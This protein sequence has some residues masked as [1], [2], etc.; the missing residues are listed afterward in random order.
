MAN[1]KMLGQ[2]A[3]ATVDAVLSLPCYLSLILNC[4]N[5]PHT[6]SRRPEDSA[7]SDGILQ[8][9]NYDQ[10]MSNKLAIFYALGL[11]AL[12]RF[13][14]F[15]GAKAIDLAPG[16]GHFSICM[17]KFLQLGSLVGVDLSEPMVATANNNAKIEGLNKAVQFTTGDITRLLNFEN[18]SFDLVTMTFA[19]HHLPNHNSLVDVISEMER[20]AGSNGTIMLMDVARLPSQEVTEKFVQLAGRDYRKHGLEFFYRDFHQSMYAAWTPSELEQAIMESS[21][22]TWVQFTLQGLPTLQILFGLPHQRQPHRIFVR[23]GSPWHSIKHILGPQLLPE[24]YLTQILFTL[25]KRHI[26]RSNPRQDDELEK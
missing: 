23:K 2:T 15:K 1:F 20:L 7:V 10:V 13:G 6:L 22:R 24:W 5:T 25:G 11:K 12:Y 8:V 3:S 4:R 14:D 21:T 17:Q 18:A 16:P 9:A 19:A 26:F